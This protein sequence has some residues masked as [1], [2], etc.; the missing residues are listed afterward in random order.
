MPIYRAAFGGTITNIGNGTTLSTTSGSGWKLRW[1][2]AS[3]VT[4]S[5]DSNNFT[6]G[7]N[8]LAFLYKDDET[9][10]ELVKNIFVGAF[11]SRIVKT[12]NVATSYAKATRV[13]LPSTRYNAAG[14]AIGG[15]SDDTKICIVTFSG[16]IPGSLSK[17]SDNSNLKFLT[18]FLTTSRYKYVGTATSRYAKVTTQ[19]HANMNLAETG[20]ELEIHAGIRIIQSTA[21]ATS[22]LSRGSNG[23]PA[24]CTL[25]NQRTDSTIVNPKVLVTLTAVSYTHLTLPTIL[26]V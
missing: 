18:D 24:E 26:L 11:G 8:Q 21:S 19:K 2:E 12:S 14:T 7:S 4:V 13:Q 15:G 20:T 1:S 22:T 5:G 9:G 3:P 10:Q 23:S 25:E 17:S 6:L 16:S